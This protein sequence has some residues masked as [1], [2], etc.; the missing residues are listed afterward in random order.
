MTN[1]LRANEDSMGASRALDATDSRTGIDYA[2]R[3]IQQSQVQFSL[4]ADTK[5]SIMMTVCSIVISAS[6]TRL[7]RAGWWLPLIVLDVFTVIALVAALVCVLPSTRRPPMKEGAV[8][9]ASP[10][11]NPF[12][13]MHFRHLTRAEFEHEFWS[14]VARPSD[15]YHVILG[16]IYA[17]G[18]VIAQAKYRYLRF[19]YLSFMAGLIAALAALFL[20]L[21]ATH[22]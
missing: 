2:L 5:A 3:T 15:L 7:D 20:Q 4:M 17:A 13:F 18:C 1:P 6:L 22:P 21:A 14:R 12:F 9:V 10:G 16:D 11:F 8:D 19:S